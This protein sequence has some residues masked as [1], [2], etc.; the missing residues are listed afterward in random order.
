MHPQRTNHMAVRYS[1]RGRVG[2]DFLMMKCATV[3][4]EMHAVAKAARIG[5][6]VMLFST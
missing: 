1:P 6:V 3:R 2:R 5:T 4:A